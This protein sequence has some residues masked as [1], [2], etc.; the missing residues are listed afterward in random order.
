M[1][2]AE[3]MAQLEAAGSEQTRKTYKRHGATDPMF[4]VSY[5]VLYKMRKAIKKDQA[6]ALQLWETGNLDARV[7]ATMVADPKQFDEKL[8][9]RWAADV[10]DYG[11]ADAFTGMLHNAPVAHTLMER[12][13]DAGDEW[14][15]RMGWGLLGEMALHHNDE[16]PDAYF[17]PYLATIGRDIHQ[18][19]NRVRQAMNTALIAIG[20]RGGALEK[21]ALELAAAIGEVMIDHGDTYCKTP[22]AAEYIL[23]AKARKKPQPA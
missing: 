6:L 22:D 9:L 13:V 11:M 10:K 4:G 8:A 17:E 19:A 7:L 14:Y 18:R 2:L 16:F 5:A 20:M 15:E 21:Q 23:K 12:W 3:A 1:K